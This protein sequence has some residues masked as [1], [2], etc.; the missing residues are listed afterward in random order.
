MA[1]R[2]PK[3]DRKRFFARIA[4]NRFGWWSVADPR[5]QVNPKRLQ[6]MQTPGKLLAFQSVNDFG[7]P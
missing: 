6:F 7:L 2:F 1:G 4:S 5:P 3:G